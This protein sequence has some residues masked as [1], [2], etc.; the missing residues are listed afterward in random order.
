M[1]LKDAAFAFVTELNNGINAGNGEE[2][3][4]AM[5]FVLAIIRAHCTP[6]TWEE[7]QREATTKGVADLRGILLEAGAEVSAIRI[8]RVGNN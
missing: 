2:V 4:R 3:S 1:S 5:Y 7:I 8:R 6:A